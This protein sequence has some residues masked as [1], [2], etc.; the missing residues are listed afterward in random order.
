MKKNFSKISIVWIQNYL[1]TYIII[2]FISYVI[3]YLIN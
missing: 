1:S 3:K 2:F